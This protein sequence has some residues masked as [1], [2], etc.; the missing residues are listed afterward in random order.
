[1]QGTLVCLSHTLF[2]Q[3]WACLAGP[4]RQAPGDQI[5]TQQA[6]VSRKVPEQQMKPSHELEIVFEQE[7]GT[8][9]QLVR[10]RLDLFN[11]AATGVSAYYPVN[12]FVRNARGEVMGGLLGGIWG[13]WMHITYL[14]LDEAVRGRRLATKLMDEAEALARERHC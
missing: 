12:F 9:A 3:S 6:I 1:S 14:W 4:S 7:G 13:G 8:A 2:L 11:I 5:R 10:D